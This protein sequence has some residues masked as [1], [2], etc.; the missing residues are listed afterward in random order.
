[1]ERKP[2]GA[3]EIDFKG[4]FQSLLN[5]RFEGV[6][7]LE[8]SYVPSTGDKEQGSRESFQGLKKILMSLKRGVEK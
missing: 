2:V 6:V 1:M 3:G 5:D 8:T 4:Q 7:S